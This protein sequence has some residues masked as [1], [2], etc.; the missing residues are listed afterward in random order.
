[1][2]EQMERVIN[3]VKYNKTVHFLLPMLGLQLGY[4]STLVNCYISDKNRPDIDNYHLFLL[5]KYKD[6]KIRGIEG[7]RTEYRTDDGHMYVFRIHPDFEE[8]YLKFI[9][10]KYSEFSE[11]YKK[12]INRLLP[13][14]VPN[15]N[16]FKVIMKTP[17]AKKVIEERIGQSI[18]NQEVMSIPNMDEEIYG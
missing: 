13:K 7:F 15:Q 3:T 17:E 4:F 16:V 2:V 5:Y 10:G 9:L 6:D 8:D 18:G 11:G 12:Q 1:M 14:P